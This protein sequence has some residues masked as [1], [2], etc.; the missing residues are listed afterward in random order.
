[1][2]ARYAVQT[3]KAVEVILWIANA[4]PG[5]DVYHV[6]KAAYFADKSHLRRFGRP[7]F[8][9]NYEAA[10]YGPLGN[11]LYGL[12]MG[13]P[14]E[15]LALGGNG[16]LPFRLDGLVVVPRREANTSLLSTSDVTAL[17]EAVEIVAPL[18]F[19]DLVEIT[20]DDPAWI[21]AQG[22]RMK[23]EDMLDYDDPDY[24]RRVA[25]LNDSARHAA[26]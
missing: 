20:H 18:S 8:G 16:H 23:Y 25:A 4:Q 11:T 9:E 24:D 17:N 3:A 2:V 22:G 1:M 10:P 5:L 7:I 12:I 26:F 14:L 6:V 15:I 13:A 19:D 21:N